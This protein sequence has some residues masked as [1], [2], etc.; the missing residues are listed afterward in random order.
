MIFLIVSAAF[1]GARSSLCR[2]ISRVFHYCAPDPK[3]NDYYDISLQLLQ[4]SSMAVRHTSA[5]IWPS[6][7]KLGTARVDQFLHVRSVSYLF[8]SVS[9][10]SEGS[11]RTLFEVHWET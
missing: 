10:L 4:D 3:L 11:S 9:K 1:E 6:F 2:L 7:T 5:L 8:R